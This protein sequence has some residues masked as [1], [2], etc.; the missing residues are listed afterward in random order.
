MEERGHRS[1]LRLVCP[2]LDMYQQI[3]LQIL[4]VQT[5]R[6][7]LWYCNGSWKVCQNEL[8]GPTSSSFIVHVTSFFG[9]PQSIGSLDGCPKVLVCPTCWSSQCTRGFT[10][11]ASRNVIFIPPSGNLSLSYVGTMVQIFMTSKFLHLSY[12]QT[13]YHMDSIAERYGQLRAWSCH[14]QVQVQQ[15]PSVC[16]DDAQCIIWSWDSCVSFLVL[17]FSFQI[18]LRIY[19]WRCPMLDYCSQGNFSCCPSEMMEA[20]L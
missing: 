10:Y 9:Q 18:N 2:E 13:R 20:S 4:Q 12:L 14:L 11:T 5:Q 17:A 1:K 6:L 19:S 3:K 7:G 15:P 8:Q 16:S